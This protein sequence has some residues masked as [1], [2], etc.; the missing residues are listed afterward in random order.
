MLNANNNDYLIE[1]QQQ[2]PGTTSPSVTE[3]DVAKIDQLVATRPAGPAHPPGRNLPRDL[4]EIAD[5]VEDRTA[6]GKNPRSLR[7]DRAVL[8]GTGRNGNAN[9][10]SNA[11]LRPQRRAA[12][13]DGG[14]RGK[15]ESSAKP[16][17]E[18]L[19]TITKDEGGALL[20]SLFPAD[21]V[22]M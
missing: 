19:V 17:R 21:E 16:Q 5:D 4:R 2:A 8:R 14:G 18:P 12:I 15:V 7:Q 1:Q 3:S 6:R 11:P 20:R 10:N 13:E 22:D 9:T